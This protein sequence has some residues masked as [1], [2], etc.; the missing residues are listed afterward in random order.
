MTQLEKDNMRAEYDFTG[1]VRG[2]SIA[3]PCK[4]GIR[5]LFIRQMAQLSLRT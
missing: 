4:L 1:G 5:S 2:Q 3:E